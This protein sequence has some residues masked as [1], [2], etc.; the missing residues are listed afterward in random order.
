MVDE[1][2]RYGALNSSHMLLSFDS[3]EDNC[4]LHE[5]AGSNKTVE[6]LRE[7]FDK[8]LKENSNDVR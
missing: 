3:F 2:K 7:E 5:I 1:I 8:M 6:Q 4:K